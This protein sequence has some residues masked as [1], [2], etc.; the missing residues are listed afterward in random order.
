MDI[1]GVKRQLALFAPPIDP[2]MLINAAAQGLSLGSILSDLSSPPPIYRFTYLIQKANEFVS[3]VKSLGSTLL[4]VLEK[5]DA[6]ELGRLRASH[7]TMMLDLMT[8]IK[9]R[10]LLDAK[11]VR[12]GLLKSRDIAKFRFKYYTQLITDEDIQVPGE[13]TLDANV[14]SESQLPADTTLEDIVPDVDVSLVD[15]DESGVKLIKKEKGEIDDLE[16][17]RFW[18]ISAQSAEG[19]AALA[20]IIPTVSADGK[21]LGVGA[22]A[23]WGGTQL[24]NAFSAG[25]K[26]FDF[27]ANFS[28]Q[29]A[30]I[31]AKMAS[32]IRREQEWTL[33]A[34]LAAKEIIQLD[35]Q[36]T[37]ADIRIQIAQKELDN[38]KKQIEN[39][40][41]VEQFLQD[42]FTN[43]ELYQW[44]KEQLFSVY[45]QS[46]NMAFDMAKKVE[47]CYQYELGIEPIN[48][49]Q[50]GY[51]DNTMQGL[52]AGE[53][54]QLALR[55]LEKSYIEENKRELELTK[56]VSIALL[57][58]L[59]LEEL[60]TTGK[61]FL[62]IPEEAY[63]LDYQ[64]HY[65]RRIKSISISIPCIAGPYT[66]IN[67][68]L[69]LL[70]N[71]VRINTSMNESGE[72]AH[73]ND[74]GMWIDDDRFRE[75]NVPVKAIATSTAQRDSG[76]FELNF[77]DERYLPFEGAG[78]LS[79]WKIELTQDTDLRLFDYSTISDIIMHISYTA[80]E[81][82]GTFKNSVVTHLKEFI[83]NVADLS[84]QPMMRMFS[85][86][87]EFSSEW[88]KFL[89]PTVAGSDQILSLTLRREHFPFFTKDRMI[90]VKKVQVLMKTNRS[91]EY[92]MI[93]SITD[94]A[95]ALPP[96]SPNI[97]T[98]SEITMP[99]N[100][101]YDNMQIATLTADSAA[102]VNINVEDMDVFR[103]LTL[104]FRHSTDVS[105]PQ[106]YNQLK[107]D[108]QEI[109]DMFV[110]LHYCLGDEI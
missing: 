82:A 88:Y 41:E 4:S 94:I 36:I 93:L 37:S 27:I 96:A 59:A 46:F 107:T 99:E 101:T 47:R 103:E 98:S 39:S 19:L 6:E 34:N 75:S 65:F 43:Q 73:N 32:Y 31:G 21:P 35:K 68:S 63:D 71:S 7:E 48:F 87:H 16:T 44:M 105:V 9:E 80:R 66:T 85:L 109:S 81:D 28:T 100:V 53:K 102:T 3:E 13:P 83:K 62:T 40:K 89:N 24:G 56:N 29:S 61:C 84:T 22:G 10:Q 90:N 52:C 108:P 67:C 97:I 79:D 106:K 74:E 14:N 95:S 26:I 50:Y 5:K 64:G 72:Y 11:A 77:R 42:K 23:S 8:A 76:M 17:A 58:P 91:G 78:A 70:K 2:A 15:S 51:W 104:R 92:K 20:H 12:E 1:D 25:G 55:Q 38:H 110:I 69:R 54:L 45:K 30:I 57:N 49:I 18:Q 60:R 86:K 33:Q